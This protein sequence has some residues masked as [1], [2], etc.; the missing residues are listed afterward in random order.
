M[1]SSWYR[2]QL[3]KGLCHQQVTMFC[4]I[5]W[6]YHQIGFNSWLTN[7]PICIIIGVVLHVYQ[8]YA[9]MLTNWHFWLELIFISRPQTYWKDN[10]I[11]FKTFKKFSLFCSFIIQQCK[12][13]LDIIMNLLFSFTIIH[14]YDCGMK[15]TYMKKT[16]DVC[17]KQHL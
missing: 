12:S 14:N 16:F 13:C 4:M 1:I 10:Y 11:F 5:I 6:V 2:N 3:I 8:P 7:K 17:L 9:S 15:I